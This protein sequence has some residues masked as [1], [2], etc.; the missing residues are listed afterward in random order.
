MSYTLGELYGIVMSCYTVGTYSLFLTE[1]KESLCPFGILYAANSGTSHLKAAVVFLDGVKGL[2]KQL[3]VFL[4]IGSD[5]MDDCVP[6]YKYASIGEVLGGVLIPV[7][8]KLVAV[9]GDVFLDQLACTD[10]LMNVI[11][12]RLPAMAEATA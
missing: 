2:F 8:A 11:A 4:H 1:L 9:E 3:E 5:E 7:D 6:T 10:S 12:E